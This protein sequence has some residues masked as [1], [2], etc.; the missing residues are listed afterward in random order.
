MSDIKLIVGLGN[1][2]NQ[3]ANTRHNAGEW[4][5][6]QLCR[7]YHLNLS[8]EN[9]FFGKTARTVVA[10]RE[11]R[12]LVPT[13]FM[14]LSGKAVGSLANFYRIQPEQILVAHDELDLPPGSAKLKQGGGHGG[15]NGLK[16]I[17]SNL[18]NSKNFY[19]LRLG[20]GHPGDKNLV[21]GYVLN[22]PPQ[23]ELKL[24][25]QAVEE[26]AVCVDLLLQDGISKAM[27]RLNGFKI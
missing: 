7:Q 21:S 18:G 24:I 15:H 20:I 2:G 12:F 13:T 25:E 3:Y 1:P 4:L 14:N 17:I 22:K 8:P 11:V 9:K 19:R 26:A 16:D 5:I 10:G 27:N 23:T 6:E